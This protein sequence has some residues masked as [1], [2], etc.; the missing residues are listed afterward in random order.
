MYLIYNYHPHESCNL[1]NNDTITEREQTYS[2]NNYYRESDSSKASSRYKQSDNYTIRGT[3][4]N[5]HNKVMTIELQ[6]AEQIL[7]KRDFI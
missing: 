1:E 2:F 3:Y 7:L 5:A 4:K 6:N